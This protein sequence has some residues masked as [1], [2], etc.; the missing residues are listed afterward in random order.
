MTSSADQ[1]SREGRFAR[2]IAPERPSALRLGVL[3][4]L[5]LLWIAVLVILY[6]ATVRPARQARPPVTQMAAMAGCVCVL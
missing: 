6:A 5:L 1:P 3:T 4:A 2:F